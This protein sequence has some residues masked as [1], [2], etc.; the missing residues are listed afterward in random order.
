MH[1]KKA[2]SHKESAFYF[3]YRFIKIESLIYNFSLSSANRKFRS[4]ICLIPL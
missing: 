1:I 3:K 4:E 2:G